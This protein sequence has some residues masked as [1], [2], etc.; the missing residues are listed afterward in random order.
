MWILVQVLRFVWWGLLGIGTEAI[1]RGFM[2]SKP[3]HVLAQRILGDRV[4][5]DK[6][7][8]KRNARHWTQ[9]RELIAHVPLGMFWVYAPGISFGFDFINWMVGPVHAT[10]SSVG[11]HALLYPFCFWGA[12]L[13]VGTLVTKKR[14][15][16]RTNAEGGTFEAEITVPKWWDY[17]D[18]GFWTINGKKYVV[19]FQ[20]KVRWDY[21]FI[22]AFMGLF[23]EFLRRAIDPAVPVAAENFV[24]S[25]LHLVHVIH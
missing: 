9:R 23:M 10:W 2:R 17:T 13:F 20:G 3:L 11:L 22:W 15:I 18:E 14:K 6:L 8:V 12:E 4:P 1:W 7:T 16:R 19:H 21:A 25:F 24:R 5:Y